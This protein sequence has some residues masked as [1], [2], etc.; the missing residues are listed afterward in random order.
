[1]NSVNVRLPH[2]LL[3]FLTAVFCSALCMGPAAAFQG[4]P[5]K[6][7]R[8]IAQDAFPSVAL[9]VMEDASGQ[10]T[11][12]GSGFVLSNGVVVTNQHVI[13]GAARGYCKLVGRSTKYD[14]AGT[15]AIDPVHDLAVLAVSGLTA[16]P[17]PIEDSDRLAVGDQL[18]AVGNPQGLE[19]TFSEGIVSGIRGISGDKVLQITAPISPG[20]SGGPIL[21]AAGKV[22][23][24]A[25]ATFTGGQNLNLAIPSSYLTKLIPS[26]SKQAVPLS[27]SGQHSPHEAHSIVKDLGGAGNK[28][29][30]AE[31]FEWK[32]ENLEDG[33]YSFSL[34][35][36]GRDAIKFVDVLVVFLD[37]NKQPVDVGRVWYGARGSSYTPV[38]PPGL[39]RRVTGRVDGS[40]Q[41]LAWYKEFR[42]LD[43][44]LAQE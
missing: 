7:A 6:S 16:P 37:R 39:A 9:L 4:N 2:S 43:F 33:E 20:S 35:N 25:V 24:I 44:E 23:G 10:P 28:A 29:V 12:L 17:L 1:M 3:T 15:V 19:G 21:N 34:R 30:L 31:H 26:I 11:S 36:Q 13:S 32:Y 27:I 40:V 18:Y 42:I 41:R 38:I 14:I 5:M 22:V 8:E